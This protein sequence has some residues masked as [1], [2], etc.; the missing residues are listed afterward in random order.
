MLLKEKV[1][2]S[3]YSSSLTILRDAHH[4]E[5]VIRNVIEAI[6]RSG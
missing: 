6:M 4:I 1:R 3:K 2:K 5:I